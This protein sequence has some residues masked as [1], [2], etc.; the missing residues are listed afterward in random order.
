MRRDLPPSAIND[1]V[2][3]GVYTRAMMIKRILTIG[4][5]MAA[6]AVGT[7][8]AQAQQGYPVPPGSVYS[9][10]PGYPPGGYVVDERRRPGAPDFDDLE[11]DDMPP[12]QNSAALPPP[13]Q[14]SDTVP[15]G[16]VSVIANLLTSEKLRF[17]VR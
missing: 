2:W 9:T 17:S 1:P 16:D 10:A 12:G 11:D 5:A 6:A 7:S 4:A 15:P 13:F 14:I 3:L 8:L